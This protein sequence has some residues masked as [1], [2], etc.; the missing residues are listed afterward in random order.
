MKIDGTEIDP[1]NHYESAEAAALLGIKKETL[2]V[3]RHQKRHLPYIKMGRRVLYRGDDIIG[4]IDAN[5]IV[6]S[7]N[8]A[9]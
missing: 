9:A 6:Q 2:A 1:Q 3:W 8:K 5:R 7:S 4:Y